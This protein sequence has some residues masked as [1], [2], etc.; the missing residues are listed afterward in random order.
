V[1]Y[2]S[3][4][5]SLKRRLILLLILITGL[6]VLSSSAAFLL[7]ERI[8]IRASLVQTIKTYAEIAANP[9][10]ADLDFGTP[11][12]TATTL[13]RFQS[14]THIRA[15][16]IYRDNRF[17]AGYPANA[18]ATAFPASPAVHESW[19][20]KSDSFEFFLPINKNDRLAGTLFIRADLEEI[21][22]RLASAAKVLAGI[23]ILVFGL[24]LLASYALQNQVTK[25][26]LQ[27]SSAAR[28]ISQ[29]KD[30]AVRLERAQGG[31]IGVLTDSLNDMLTQIQGRDARLMDY[32]EHLEEQVAQRSEQLMKAN[33]QLLVAKEKAEDANKAKS[34][35]LANMSHEL[36]TPLN[37]ILLYSELLTDEVRERGMAELVPDL[38]KIQSAGKHLLSLIN[39]I[40][41][42]SKIEAGRMNITMEECELSSFLHDIQTT[43]QPL[44]A[45][46]HN[47]LVVEIDPSISQIHTDLRM[48]RQIL[49]NL[50]N[51]AAKF[52]EQGK[53][54]FRVAQDGASAIF[55]IEDSG[56]GMTEE[57]IR[58]VFHEFTQ[59]DESTTRRFGGTGLGLAL[60]RKLTSLLGG[61][62]TVIS[63]P[64]KGSTFTLRLPLDAQ[65]KDAILTSQ[66]LAHP[67]NPQRKILIIDD[68]PA[69]RE[70]LSRILTQEGF[71]AAVARD[72]AEGLQLAH[73]LHPD[74]I[75]LDIMMPG[76]DGWQVLA[77]LKDDP[78]LRD[79]PVVLLTILEDRARGFALGASEYLCKPISRD[80]LVE[81]LGRLGI[82]PTGKPLLLVED[83]PLTL[84]AL[85][86]I[87]ESEGWTVHTAKDGFLAMEH[88]QREQP[89][90]MLL[91][92]M[93]PGMDGFQLVAEMQQHETLREIPV[94]ILTAK[95]LTP[96][97]L[98]RLTGPPVRQVL[99]K[100]TFSKEDLLRTVRTLALQS[101]E[102]RPPDGAPPG[103]RG[104]GCIQD[105]IK[106]VPNGRLP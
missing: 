39:D 32:Q 52:T 54:T 43:V 91:D 9:L 87:L 49:Y 50:L 25:P 55:L 95:D 33:T 69:M 80:N 4:K 16:C 105:P 76:L 44:V 89:S 104:E 22:A 79:I 35:F 68:D 2:L 23:A 106:N 78:E 81:V 59:A 82:G 97:E 12:S 7:F 40:L 5:F 34:T 53:I 8:Q 26:I 85:S 20:F 94:L 62:L 17:F 46:N 37:A 74:V 14:N 42:L 75:T 84:D 51:N 102:R 21:N 61:E 58:R 10:E 60:S 28:K 30:Y 66:L 65:S 96:M 92:L 100:G 90:L 13:S 86:R 6:S 48:L 99:H 88:L 31:E 27:L 64:G 77:Q 56:I 67:G 15:A 38:G 71:W 83:N 73:T 11:A 36:R 72:G 93:M 29:E 47:S 98:D 19:E 57:Q 41:D 45:K 63:E 18:P 1:L 101:L 70:G 3:P 103:F 24:V